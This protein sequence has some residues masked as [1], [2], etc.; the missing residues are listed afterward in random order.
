MR[1]NDRPDPFMWGDSEQL[2]RQ[3]NPNWRPYNEKTNIMDNRQT[4]IK[5]EDNTKRE[6][7]G[8]G[9]ENKAD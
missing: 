7:S 8:G 9:G 5:N 3:I 1:I 4:S 2:Q 6:T